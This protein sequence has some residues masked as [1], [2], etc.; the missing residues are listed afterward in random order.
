MNKRSAAIALG[1][2]AFLLSVWLFDGFWATLITTLI[3]VGA[4]ITVDVWRESK[5]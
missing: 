4:G 5:P 3:G 1:L 2:G